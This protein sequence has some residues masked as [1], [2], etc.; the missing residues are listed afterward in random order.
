MAKLKCLSIICLLLTI[1]LPARAADETEYFA[2]FMQ[3]KKV[4]YAI[5]TRKVASQEVTTSEEVSITISRVGIPVTV[6]MTEASVETTEGK[7]LGF[8]SIQLLGFV[9]MKVIG[10]INDQGI[11]EV[12]NSSL[13][14]A[15]KSTMEWPQGAMMAEGLRLLT[16]EKGLETGTEYTAKIFNPGMMQA[17][18]ATVAIG[19]KKDVDLL[20][21]I[22]KLT[23]M[24]TTLAMPGTGPIA[25]TSYVDDELS[26]LKNSMAVAGMKVDMV[27]CAKEFALGDND[28]LE[29]IGMM[30]ID[31]PTSLGNPRSA[32]AITYWLAPNPGA[33]FTVPTTDNQ[34][35]ERLANGKIKLAIRP[36]SAPSRAKFPYKGDDPELLEAVKPTRFL[37]SDREDI[38]KL[39]RKAAGNTKDAAKAVE[40]IESFV[41]D[42]IEDKSLSVGY[43]S[44]A[45]V[46]ESRQ[47]DCSE[48]A[49]LTAALCRAVGIPAQVVVGIAYVQDFAGHEG[50]GGH[51]WTQAYVGG[52][53]VGLDAAFKSSGRG[54]Y[55]AGHIALAVG[56]GEPADFFNMASA[57][58]AFKIE[59]LEVE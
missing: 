56:N 30:F 33:N 31:S 1:C 34:K 23:E 57:L 55:D 54:G 36:V 38:V 6:K 59:K 29:L 27:A 45:E 41:A 21:R 26:A 9:T 51:A 19:E 2:V 28:V 46:L 13:G 11:I 12:T 16:L 53:W 17:I 14:S 40:R 49:V 50:F 39:A 42:Y 8:E 7:P 35:A 18:D 37:Q 15:Q 22:V 32:A 25:S 47:G 52:H 24:T 5:H 58:G 3:G 43:A 44:A 20:G 10:A 4:G 48:F